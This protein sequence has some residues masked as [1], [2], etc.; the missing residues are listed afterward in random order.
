MLAA[1]IKQDQSD[2]MWL[3]LAAISRGEAN[4]L[5]PEIAD[6]F[7]STLR[8]ARLLARETTLLA[9]Y[10]GRPDVVS[11]AAQLEHV[12]ELAELENGLGSTDPALA[13]R[14][15]RKME[16]ATAYSR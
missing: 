12:P 9:K 7:V 6:Q 11:L 2:L 10:L 4:S 1:M 13:K 14:L 5:P 16:M 3:V 8:E 15:L